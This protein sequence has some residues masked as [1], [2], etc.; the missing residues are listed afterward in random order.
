MKEKL[1]LLLLSLLVLGLAQDG[2]QESR[3]DKIQTGEIVL[4]PNDLGT[5]GANKNY[6]ESLSRGNFGATE[7]LATAVAIAG[8]ETSCSQSFFSLIVDIVEPQSENTKLKL[9]ID[10]RNKAQNALTTWTKVKLSYLVASYARMS[11]TLLN[12]G[13]TKSAPI[14]ATSQYIDL[15]TS[16]NN[17]AVLTDSVL[18]G[19]DFNAGNGCGLFYDT[20]NTKWRYGIRCDANTQ[21]ASP[22]SVDFDVA[23]HT[24]IMGFHYAPDTGATKNFLAAEVKYD[25]TTFTNNIKKYELAFYNFPGSVATDNRDRQDINTEWNKL[26]F[27]TQANVYTMTF[28]YSSSKSGPV[29]TI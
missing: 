10:F 3:L 8:F 11:A 26:T 15:T 17:A 27:A 28:S 25:T 4:N 14:W 21:T 1:V 19:A 9:V 22:K 29:Y 20:A 2:C 7:I 6:I 13:L 16:V 24:Y 23:V 18:L 12:E 5:A